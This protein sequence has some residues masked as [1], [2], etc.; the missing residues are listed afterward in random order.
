MENDRLYP[1][2]CFVKWRWVD[3]TLVHKNIHCF[4][5]RDATPTPSCGKGKDKGTCMDLYSV[6]DDKYLVLNALRHGSQFNLQTTPCLP[7]AFV[8]DH[9]MAPPWTVVTTS[10]CSLLL[11]YRPRKDE[12][13]SWPSWLAYSGRFTNI[14]GHPSAVGRAQDSESSPVKDQRSTAETAESRNQPLNRV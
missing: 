5:P 2:Y 12:M 4:F 8:C 14:S 9:Q 7:L 11:I 6:L 10:S 3:C 1:L 13:L